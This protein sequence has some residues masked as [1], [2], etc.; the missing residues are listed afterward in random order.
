[1]RGTMGMVVGLLI[2]LGLGIAWVMGR[3]DAAPSTAAESP[4]TPTLGPA[5]GFD[6]PPTEIERV[7]VGTVAPDFTLA[8]YS[9][10]LV[11]LS[12]YRGTHNVVL[13]F[14]RGHW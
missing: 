12:D 8:S 13:V 5:D 2:L 7:A 3:S 11:T 9:G 10:E 14:Y 1:M 4:P 6:L